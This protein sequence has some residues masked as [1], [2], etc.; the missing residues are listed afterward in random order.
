MKWLSVLPVVAVLLAVALTLGFYWPFGTAVQGL[1]LPGVVEIQEVRLGSKIGGRVAA[2][3]VKEGIVVEPGRVLVRFE[4]PELEATLLQTQGRLEAAEAELAKA[5][6]GPRPDEKLAA[7]SAVWA[8]QAR[9]KRLEKGWRDE[10]VSQAT[11]DLA[12]ADAELRFA[13]EEFDRADKLYGQGKGGAFSRADWDAARSIYER[14]KGRRNSLQ[15]RLDMLNHG[16]RP[17]EVEEAQAELQRAQANHRLLEIGTRQED[18]DAA[19]A[20]VKEIQGKLAEVQAQ[21]K[22]AEVIAPERAFVDVVAVRKG[23]LVAPNQP[24]VRV[25]RADDLWVKVYVPETEL[26]KISVGQAASVTIDSYPDKRFT[27]KVMHIAA[28]SEFTPRNVQSVDERR[29]QVF[30]VKIQVDDPQQVFKAGMA[31]QVTFDLAS[32]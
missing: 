4:E 30:G 19:R 24:I 21:L 26:G 14:A 16:T 6:A 27:G 25:L 32:R 10:E 23:D 5:E 1:H 9:L 3:E 12:S 28:E 8:T 31:A 11:S 2:V 13:K 20:R 29:H 18:K 22:E 7:L 15:F 17:E